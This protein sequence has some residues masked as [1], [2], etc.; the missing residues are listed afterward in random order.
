MAQP[1]KTNRHEDAKGDEVKIA[2][3]K[4]TTKGRRRDELKGPDVGALREFS[5]V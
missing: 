1:R 4:K 5:V 3:E 2:A